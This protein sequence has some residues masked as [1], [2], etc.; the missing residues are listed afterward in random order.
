GTVAVSD[1]TFAIAYLFR[2]GVSAGCPAHMDVNGDGSPAVSDLTLL[3]GYLFRG[4][5]VPAA[6]P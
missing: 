6:C 3:I 1:L 5:P 4:G 2:G